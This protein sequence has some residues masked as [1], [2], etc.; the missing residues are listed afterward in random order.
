MKFR[1][2]IRIAFESIKS[3]SLRTFLTAFIITIGITALVGILTA[4]D[5][6]ESSLTSSFTSMGAN[7]FTIRN[8]GMGI[9]SGG[10]GKR[11][12][13]F[14]PITY[15]QAI[16]FK[17]RF[18]Y[19]ATVAISA[20]A[21]RIATLKYKSE[22]TNPNIFIFGSDEN[23]LFNSGLEIGEGRSFTMTELDHGDNVIIIGSEISKKLFKQKEH[24]IDKEISVGNVR[25]RVIGVMKEK[26]TSMGM[27]ADKN[28]IIPITNLKEK[29]ATQNTS[30]AVSV[31]AN[32]TT[33]MEDAIG[34]ATGLMRNIRR[35]EVGVQSSFE[36]TKSDGLANFLIE[37]TSMFRWVAIIIALIT[38]FGAAIGLMNIMLVSV[39]ERTREIGIR[40]AT[41]ANSKNIRRQFLFESIMICQIG[42]TGGIILGILLGNY[43]GFIMSVGFIIPWAWIL[44]AYVLCFIVGIASGLYPASKAAKL[45]PIEALRYE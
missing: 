21:S 43:M 45:D 2:Y 35:D 17:D 30:Y 3:Q 22:K 25:Y 33:Q 24:P 5:A 15:H 27:S 28:C 9:H 19:P 10:P 18:E 34:E 23:Y 31:R 42:G 14:E 44:I 32:L 20:G 8:M 7:S 4:I 1:E 29:Y 36:I 37:Q 26:G 13:R 12:Q 41:G 38:L 6:I 39:T 40:K 11:P 16:E